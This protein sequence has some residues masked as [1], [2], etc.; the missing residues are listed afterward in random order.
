MKN[1]KSLGM[2]GQNDLKCFLELNYF[3]TVY[4]LFLYGENV[5]NHKK[6]L[7]LIKGDIRD[8]SLLRKSNQVM[9][10]KDFPNGRIYINPY[11]NI[12]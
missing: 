5:F 7:R 12:K 10:I 6:D 2:L 1:Q 3:V 4:D 11:I 8:S 9:S